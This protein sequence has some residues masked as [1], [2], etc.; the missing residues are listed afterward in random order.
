MFISLSKTLTKVGGVRL[1]V[2]MRIT[3][4]NSIWMSLLVMMV[5]MFK[6]MWYLMVVMFWMI[7]AMFYGLYL[8]YKWLFKF[9]IIAYK[10][11]K[12]YCKELFAKI[13]K[14]GNQA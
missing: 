4:S 12:P 11:V 6:A 13:K 1:G 9:M 14:E 2:G 8:A 5:Q 10:K 3:K 7:Y